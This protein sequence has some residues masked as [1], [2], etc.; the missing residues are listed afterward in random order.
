MATRPAAEAA[1]ASATFPPAGVSAVVFDAVGTLVEPATTVA[2]TYARAGRRHGIDLDPAT[3]GRRFAAAWRR[4]EALDAVAAIPFATSRDRERARWREIVADVFGA[5]DTTSAIF[6]DLWEHFAQP[7]AWRPVGP[8]ENLLRAAIDAG[9]A[10]AVASNFDERL[11]VIAPQVEPLARVTAVFPSSE[12]GW[13]KPAAAFF[14]HLEARLGLPPEQLLY[15]G[16]DPELDVAA[17]ADAGWQAR[18]VVG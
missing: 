3:V 6:A 2:D 5:G 18:L 10:V 14:R 11:L 15:V 9:L 8:G 12:I 4:Q 1:A 17:A 7:P 16:D 13:R